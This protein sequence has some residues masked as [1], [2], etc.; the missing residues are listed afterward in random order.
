MRKTLTMLGREAAAWARQGQLIVLGPKRPRTVSRDADRVVAFVHGYGAAGAVFEPLRCEVEKK[1]GVPTIDFTYRSIASFSEITGELAA[2]LDRVAEGR[3]LDLV[4]HS[5]GG[6]LSRWYAQEMDGARHVDRIVTLATPHAG[7][8]SARIAPGPLRHAL[9][10]G[11]AVVRRLAAGRHRAASVAHTALVAG[12]DL[13][14]T[15]PSS[16][17][18]V[19][20]ARVRWFDDLGHNAML[21]AREVHDEVLGALSEDAAALERTG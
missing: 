1:L 9:L 4:G 12:A 8:G 7:T 11:S 17:A 16:A 21:Y 14:V 5:L 13:M 18:A 3:R 15:P 2:L 20:D 6:L 10:P 19:E